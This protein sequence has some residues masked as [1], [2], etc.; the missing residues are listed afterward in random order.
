[1]SL[2]T[3]DNNAALCA[4]DRKKNFIQTKKNGI[5]GGCVKKK[6][7]SKLSKGATTID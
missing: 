2:T 6:P 7:M 1:M 4:K 3:V 5:F